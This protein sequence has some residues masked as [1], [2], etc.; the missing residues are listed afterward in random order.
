MLA[1][2]TIWFSL[3]PSVVYFFRE[4]E[5]KNITPF[6]ALTGSFYG[7]FFGFSV[8]LAHF[9]YKD[10]LGGIYF[11]LNE[12]TATNKSAY[13]SEISATAQ[14]IVLIGIVLHLTAWGLTLTL[15]PRFDPC[16]SLRQPDRPWQ[17]IV[18]A[19]VLIALYLVFVTFPQVRMFPSLGQFVVPAGYVG[20]GLLFVLAIKNEIG[21]WLKWILILGVI[22]LWLL[23][24]VVTGFLSPAFLAIIYL[25]ILFKFVR[26]HFPWG[27]L[28]LAVAIF[29]AL[30]P[31]MNR[32]RA[33]SWQ[34]E[35][36]LEL[37]IVEYEPHRS[38]VSKAKLLGKVLGQL[39]LNHEPPEYYV[40]KSNGIFVSQGLLQR[41]AG[42]V[43]FNYVY[44]KT[45]SAVAYWSGETYLPLLTNWVPRVF[46]TE[47]PREE[48]GNKFG[49][50]YNIVAPSDRGMSIN[51]PWIT[52]FYA[53]FGTLGVLFGMA[54]VGLFMG[55]LE[56]F[57]L[58]Q[59]L[60]DSNIT[61]GWA[62]LL[63]L[64]S[65]ESNLSLMLGSLPLLALCLWV[66][67]S[68]GTYLVE[69]VQKM[70]Q[71]RVSIHRW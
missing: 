52:E 17:K 46:W 2:L 70:I 31:V 66:Y 50:R 9:M 22:P 43:L 7:I 62:I 38:L 48:T 15:R 10:N 12:Y 49:R 57:F 18:L 37:G 45:P 26:K 44:N 68:M 55:A 32:Y 71:S 69:K 53:N 51:L 27:I 59:N 25:A 39:Y 58:H 13:I 54:F 8:F 6:M 40:S 23:S 14:F 30:Y 47:K 19:G 35:K 42:L 61:T 63:P 5:S 67:F 4:L 34:Y 3:A 1:L 41:T 33:Y 24:M 16:F 60:S 65:Q 29:S 28:L 36:R 21:A 11:Y 64:F 56:R 20:F